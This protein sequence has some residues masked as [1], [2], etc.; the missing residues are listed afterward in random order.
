MP[1][2]TADDLKAE[3][4]RRE[5]ARKQLKHFVKYTLRNYENAKH[6]TILQ[7]KL[8]QVEQYIRSKGET[9][10]GRLIVTMPPRHGKSENVSIRFPA[11]FLGR[12]PDKRIILCSYAA[13]LAEKFSKKCRDLVESTEFKRVFSDVTSPAPVFVD[14]EKR[15]VQSWAIQFMQDGHLVQGGEFNAAGVGGSIT[16]MGADLL[17]IDDPIKDHEEA[18]SE[19]IREKIFDW[20]SS[21]AY[22]RL[23]RPGG[24][25]IV[26]MTRWH[27]DDL[28]GRLL[29]RESGKWT[30]LN[31]PFIADEDSTPDALGRS[32]GDILWPELYS[33]KDMEDIKTTVTP[34]DWIAMFQQRPT[35][36]AG[37]IFKKEWFRYVRFPHREDITKCIQVWDTAMT[38]KEESDYS[39]CITAMV[40]RDGVYIADVFRARLDFP[41][42]KQQMINQYEHW[43]D[44][45]P[46]SRIYIEQKQSGISVRQSLKKDTYLPVMELEKDT[47]MGKSKVQRANAAS[48]YVQ[49]GR[50][51]FPQS[52]GWLTDFETELFSF[53]RG[54]HDDMVDAFVHAVNTLNGGGKGKK[55]PLSA[56][57]KR[58]EDM[59]IEMQNPLRRDR[60]TELTGGWGQ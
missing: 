21:T 42:L 39:A 37:E 17:I 47:K 30:V 2:Y 26:M 54:K 14:E 16:G 15:R 51:S 8:E 53:P 55:K 13:E 9:G 24:A 49:S 33:M 52:A 43:N 18:N 6:Q 41:S 22:T 25:V 10:I 23:Q 59:D 12:N 60:H 50:V 3:R 34:R 35:S 58:P 11:W 45:F 29:E 57:R 4:I 28:I 27:E 38:E 20:Y 5:L 36:G 7:E 31:L 44:I 40:T 1:K 32:P 19:T 48:G 56:Y 46:V